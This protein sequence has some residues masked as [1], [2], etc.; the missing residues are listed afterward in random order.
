MSTK[1]FLLMRGYEDAE[2]GWFDL[3]DSF[4]TIEDAEAQV[5]RILAEED[6]DEVYDWYIVDQDEPRSFQPHMVEAFRR[7][8]PRWEKPA[9]HEKRAKGWVK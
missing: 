4:D 3:Q 5:E 6:E 8:R 1:R 2:G 7:K 9:L